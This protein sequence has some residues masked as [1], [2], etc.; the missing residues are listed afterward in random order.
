MPRFA[1]PPPLAQTVGLWRGALRLWAGLGLGAA[2]VGAW[3]QTADGGRPSIFVC[4]DASGRRITSDRPIAECADR[5]QR[6]ITPAGVVKRVIAPPISAQERAQQEQQRQAEQ[7]RRIKELEQQRRDRALLQR[8]PNQAQHDAERARQLALW[9]EASA[10]LRKR[11]EELQRNEQELLAEMEFYQSNP[12]KAPAWLKRKL[13]D[14]NEELKRHRQLLAQQE[15]EKRRIQQRFDEEL[16]RLK[17]LWAEQA[18]TGAT[19]PAS[20]RPR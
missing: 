16:A 17:Q 1:A 9:S 3:A 15:E 18:T 12:D 13:A 5:E 6:E 10:V 11:G 7:A 8:Y 19:A 14:H 4:V 2:A 20:I